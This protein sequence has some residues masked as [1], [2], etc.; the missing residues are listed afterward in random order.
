MIN[1]LLKLDKFVV[2]HCELLHFHVGKRELAVFSNFHHVY[3]FFDEFM[4]ISCAVVATSGFNCILSRIL[5][6][7]IIMTDVTFE[8]I[9]FAKCHM[10]LKMQR[11]AWFEFFA[12]KRTGKHKDIV[13]VFRS[14]LIRKDFIA[15]RAVELNLVE[16][17]FD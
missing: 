9:A 2:L 16:K 6:E 4:G 13:A 7:D 8:V 3:L 11:M 15:L 17:L 14:I 10:Q 1:F 5:L 12:S